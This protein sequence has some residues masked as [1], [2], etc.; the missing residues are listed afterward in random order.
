MQY[1]NVEWKIIFFKF[2]RALTADALKLAIAGSSGQLPL[3]AALAADAR[4][5]AA[6]IRTSSTAEVVILLWGL[7]ASPCLLSF[8]LSARHS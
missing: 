6:V 4:A 1:L 3:P 5:R 2:Q 7:P 8:I